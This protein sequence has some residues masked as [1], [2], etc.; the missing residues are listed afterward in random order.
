VDLSII[1]PLCLLAGVW[2]LHRNA[3][4]YLVGFMLLY[5]LALMGFIVIGQTLFQIQ[6][7]IFFSTGQLIGMIGSWIVMGSIAIGFVINMLRNVSEKSA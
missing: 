1:T 4:G 5:L 7:G 3:R 6:A 2:L